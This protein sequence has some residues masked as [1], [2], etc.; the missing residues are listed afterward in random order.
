M[1]DFIFEANIAHY[2]ELLAA[3]TDAR[4][5]AIL[6]KLLAEER[7]KLADW[8]AKNRRPTAAE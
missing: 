6:Q 4:K 2:K 3:E 7:A 8:H 5:I 1:P